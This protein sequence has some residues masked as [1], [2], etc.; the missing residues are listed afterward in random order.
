MT[1]SERLLTTAA[2]AGCLH[3]GHGVAVAQSGCTVGLSTV[4][5]PATSRTIT[6]AQSGTAHYRY[7]QYALDAAAPG[8][9]ILVRAGVYTEP[10]YLRVSGTPTAPV[11]LKAYPGERPVI[12]PYA[13]GRTANVALTGRWLV[14]DGFEIR[15][16]R[17]GV[18]VS[19][20]NNL[21]Q[22]NYIHDNGQG[23][24]GELCGQGVI[25]SSASDVAIVNNRIE[26]NGLN[27]V[28]PWL[29]HGIYVSDYFGPATSR[30]SVIGNTVREHA[31]A[32]LQAWTASTVTTDV[33]LQGNT[34]ENN[35]MEVILSSVQN[36]VLRSNTFVHTGTH[37]ATNAP[38]SIM[39]WLDSSRNVAFEGN[40]FRYRAVSAFGVPTVPLQWYAAS[41]SASELRWRRNIWD[42]PG[43]GL[44]DSMLNVPVTA[45]APGRPTIVASQSA[46]NPVSL[47]WVAGHGP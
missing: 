37:P 30:V 45:A 8:D 11:T 1:F 21:V 5:C 4:A 13:D 27:G 40:T 29:L 47:T 17:H 23:C 26:R 34:F 38:R 25:V 18:V 43:T 39:L 20:G 41:Q 6:V 14:L 19:G 10:V 46:S 22:N 3:V 44:S 16:G 7:I 31:G 12:Q 24:P 42:A 9:T 2:M 33:L 36:S 15:G 35:V 28:S 32:G